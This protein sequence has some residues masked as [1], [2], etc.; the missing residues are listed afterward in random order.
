MAIGSL[1]GSRRSSP[2]PT[3]SPP[4]I[5]PDSGPFDQ[6]RGHFRI[7]LPDLAEPLG[8]QALT[9]VEKRPDDGR[10]S[11]GM[12]RDWTSSE[13]VHWLQLKWWPIPY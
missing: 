9:G 7:L 1:Q 4:A 10:T 5:R 2:T 11:A 8:L 6:T 12:K 3:R 13:G